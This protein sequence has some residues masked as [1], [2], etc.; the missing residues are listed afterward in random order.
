MQVSVSTHLTQKE[1]STGMRAL[2]K[3]LRTKKQNKLNPLHILNLLKKQ[4]N[5]YLLG[6][7]VLFLELIQLQDSLSLQ[8]RLFLLK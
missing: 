1:F 3:T 8:K 5:I 2:K 7:I 4:S 6:G